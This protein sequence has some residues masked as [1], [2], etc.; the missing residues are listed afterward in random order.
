MHTIQLRRAGLIAFVIGVIVFLGEQY[1]MS[2]PYYIGLLVASRNQ[3]AFV[4]I[5]WTLLILRVVALGLIIAGA[6]M[7]I[8][9]RRQGRTDQTPK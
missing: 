2:L 9:G 4:A 5:S 7:F 1:I 3:A 8:L 6:V